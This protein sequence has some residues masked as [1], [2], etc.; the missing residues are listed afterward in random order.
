MKSTFNLTEDAQKELVKEGEGFLRAFH[1]EHEKDPNGNRTHYWR[2]HLSCWRLMLS[3][4]FGQSTADALVEE[5]KNKTSLT[6]PHCGPLAKDGTQ[7]LGKDAGC[8]A[9]IGRLP[10]PPRLTR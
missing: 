4:L 9:F 6:I 10:W 2:G 3:T 8:D 7:L 5:V 1:C